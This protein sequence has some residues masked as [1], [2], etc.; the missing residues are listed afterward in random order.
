MLLFEDRP[1]A[2]AGELLDRLRGAGRRLVLLTGDREAPARALAEEL[3][4]A[5]VHARATPEQKLRFVSDLCARG[6][7][8]VMV[9]DGVNDAAALAA[10]TVSVVMGKRGSD[11]AI[12]Q[13]GIVLAQ[14]RFSGLVD[15]LALS[16]RARR[17]IRQNLGISIGAMVLLAL[18]AIIGGLPLPVAVMGHEG[19]TVVVCLNSLRL[20]ASGRGRHR[21]AP[22][23]AG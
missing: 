23:P 15:A 19:S 16:E 13:A 12:A 22:A 11:A 1:R 3:R 21:S 14:D 17:V 9:G 18:G 6:D 8:V 7:K 10:A 4:I 2:D 5:E 20:L